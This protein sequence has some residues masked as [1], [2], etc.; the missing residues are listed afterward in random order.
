MN[1]VTKPQQK[2]WM[3]V[4]L[5]A[6][7]FSGKGWAQDPVPA[8]NGENPA[9]APANVPPPP[10]PPANGAPAGA[11]ELPPE[12]KMVAPNPPPNQPPPAA[13][14]PPA[15]NAPA[16]GQPVV[17]Q[18]TTEPAANG[19]AAPTANKAAGKNNKPSK[20]PPLGAPKPAQAAQ[21]VPAPA[22]GVGNA[23]TSGDDEEDEGAQ[24]PSGDKVGADLVPD[25]Q[26][27]VNIDFPEPTDIKDIIRAVSLWTG[28]NVILG[29]DVSGKVQMI[30]PRKVTKVEA[31]QAFL[32]ALNLLG[33][34]T[35][36]TGKVIKIVP[37]RSAVKSNLKTFLGATWTPLTDELI[38]Q[39][40]PLK[41]ISAKD[42][43]TTLSRIVSSNSMIAYE[44][45]NT[46][47]ISDSG[48]KVRRI[49][50]II[51]LIDVQTQ[52]PKLAIVPIRYG[53]A[54][55]IQAMVQNIFQAQDKTKKAASHMAYKIFIDER[56]NSVI[57]FG[58]PRTIADVKEL[59][60]KFDV[61][62]DDPSRQSQIHVRPLDY[63]SATKL[64]STLSSLA[65]GGKKST[66]SMRR[67]PIGGA[68]G[69]AGALGGGGGDSG[70]DPV[71]ATLDND[72]KITA[73]DSSNSLLITGSRAA[74]DAVNSI[75]RKLDIRRSQV[76][77]EAEILDINVDGGFKFGTNI[78]AGYGKEDPKSTKTAY[79]WQGGALG[80]LITRQ[81]T[82]SD[83]TQSAAAA[84]DVF[85]EDLTIGILSGVEVNVPGLGKI[86]PGA[87]I[88]M[89]K[90]DAYTRI[91][92]SPHVLTS[93]NE[94]A[95]ITVGDKLFY[96]TSEVSTSGTAVSKAQHE[97]VDLQLEIKPNISNSNYIT[98]KIDLD[99]SNGKI[100]SISGLPSVVKRKTSQIVTVKNQQTVV[101]SG[102]LYT[103]E[104][105]NYQKIPLLGDIPILG[106]LFRNSTVSKKNNNLMIFLTP[107]IVHGAN[108]LAAIYQTKL[109]QRDEFLEKVYGSDFK[110]DEFYKML[111][112][113]RQGVYSADA[114]DVIDDRNSLKRKRGMLRD[115]GYS[116]R[117]IEQIEKANAAENKAME[118]SE[119]KAEL[120]GSEEP[121][122]EL[123]PSESEAAPA[124]IE[125]TPGPMLEPGSS[126]DEA[127]E[128]A[129]E[130]SGAVSEPIEAE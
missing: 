27:L 107:Y 92:S 72:V 22:G 114:F 16:S 67:P 80:P 20:R 50:D 77:V 83:S 97:D 117:E 58:P 49:L 15:E 78:F 42:I 76:F 96:R 26:E 62:V 12:D 51:E 21:P 73:D 28:K 35:V 127:I 102:L 128:A 36:E 82:K 30:S 64:A 31:Y 41:Y 11:P 129:P 1:L 44:P 40:V 70:G 125:D 24:K 60:K 71:V 84:A 110:E 52:Q 119:E 23:T 104:N 53:D 63:A 108:D 111:P 8:A 3:M 29:R 61:R 46:L 2:K 43:Q 100:D 7:L 109:K 118:P 86:S 79:A 59:V 38:T 112:G 85:K 116:Q 130:D 103:A 106:W 90:T 5:V 47:I 126:S 4:L 18:P 37:V 65:S 81:V 9:A 99:A 122:S 33:L 55:S 94:T 91:L 6:A 54:K 121:T 13:A 124:E 10:P 45:T 115:M 17:E 39:I 25:G 74:Y 32:S 75:V 34:T 95:K 98:L 56:T 14:V 87:I 93:N 101:I 68:P 88:K 89:I 19:G 113:E 57:I 69:D 66:G 120:E 105:E 123:P 48:Y